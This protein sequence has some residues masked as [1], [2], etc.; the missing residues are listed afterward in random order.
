MPA[1]GHADPVLTPAN[2]AFH[3]LSVGY[4]TVGIGGCVRAHSHS[5]QVEVHICFR[6]RGRIVIEGESHRLVPGTVCFIGYHVKQEIWNDGD[7]ELVLIWI[8]SPPG[9]EDFFATIGRWRRP[10][11]PAPAPFERRDD[12]VQIERTMGMNDTRP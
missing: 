4:Q 3:G 10:G 2:T 12:V 9:L 1:N 7:E 6:G 8:I 11:E 5:N